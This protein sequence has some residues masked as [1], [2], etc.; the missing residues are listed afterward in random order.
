MHE[1]N[2]VWI[3]IH[4]NKESLSRLLWGESVSSSFPASRGH[5]YSLAHG[6]LPSSSKSLPL[7]LSDLSSL[8]MSPSDHGW[9]RVPTFKDSLGPS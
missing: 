9:E 1:E 5:Q 4:D 2:L 3:S 6:P 7:H 8:V